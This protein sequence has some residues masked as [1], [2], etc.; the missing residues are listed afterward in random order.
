M[1]RRVV[2]YLNHIKTD[3]FQ[4]AG[5]C[6]AICRDFGI[7]PAILEEDA[8]AWKSHFSNSIPIETLTTPEE[9]DAL[10]VFGG[11]GTVLRAMDE[12]VHLGLLFLGINLGRLG[13]LPEVQTVEMKSAIARV[14][15]GEY[16]LE[17]RMMLSYTSL[18]KEGRLH[19]FATNEVSVSRGLSQR[20]IA[21]DV[22]ADGVVV[23]HYIADGVL[24]AS[25][26]GSTAYSLSAGGPIISP[27]LDCLLI[28]PICPH[29]LV[30]RPI[31][32]SDHCELEINLNMTETREGIQLS[33]DGV[34][35]G[36]LSVGDKV[37]VKRS[38]YDALMLRLD[39]DRNFYE[40]L[41]SKLVQSYL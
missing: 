28:N 3:V 26:T 20:M 39:K 33:A 19:G 38:P 25:P 21:M 18:E 12:Y 30:S 34:T 1:I 13:F 9:A 35:L 6:A 40:L 15:R 11:D 14:A 2:F 41:K 37:L 22:R 7:S 4:I 16:T 10:F 27:D 23:E 17:H 5:D 29:T 8:I 36:E 31:V 32:L 24:V